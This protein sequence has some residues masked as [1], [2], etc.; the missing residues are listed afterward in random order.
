MFNFFVCR[1]PII[2]PQFIFHPL[3]QDGHCHRLPQRSLR[4][5][6]F[7]RASLPEPYRPAQGGLQGHLHRG[8]AFWHLRRRSVL[9]EAEGAGRGTHPLRAT[10]SPEEREQKSIHCMSELGSSDTGQPS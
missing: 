7:E 10:V 3:F 2:L 8:S 6:V 9:P 5:K 4:A 1:S